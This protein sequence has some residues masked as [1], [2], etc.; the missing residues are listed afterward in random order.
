V[1]DESN[2]Q[3][4]E[5]NFE[6]SLDF[7]QGGE[8][9]RFQAFGGE[10]SEFLRILVIQS[11]LGSVLIGGDLSLLELLL[12]V[13]SRLPLSRGTSFDFSFCAL[14]WS[15]CSDKFLVAG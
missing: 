14:I 11:C 6:F 10:I 9:S 3:Q 8:T 7:F 1:L 2:C 15:L 5:R 13:L 4:G 12:V